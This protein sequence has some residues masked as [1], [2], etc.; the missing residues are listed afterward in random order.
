MAACTQNGIFDGVSTASPPKG[1]W[2]NGE[3]RKGAIL[4]P[5]GSAFEMAGDFFR[6]TRP[7]RL[8]GS[9]LVLE[10]RRKMQVN[11]QRNAGIR[12]VCPPV[13]P[14]VYNLA[15]IYIH[16]HY[17]THTHITPSHT[18]THIIL[19][20]HTHTSPP[21]P[22]YTHTTPHTLHQ[23]LHLS[24]YTQAE[25]TSKSPL[26]S[27]RPA[28]ARRPRV[29]KSCIRSSGETTGAGGTWAELHF[30]F[31]SLRPFSQGL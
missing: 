10:L 11:T 1:E 13:F 19:H 18:H 8:L 16:T 26:A 3:T 17:A 6:T 23:H 29:S 12:F 2:R 5:L 9:H 14:R 30:V 31:H 28:S 20:K 24:V 4:W 27:R 22:H 21:S 25:R 15:D 7:A